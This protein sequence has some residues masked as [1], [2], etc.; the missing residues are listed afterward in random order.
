MAQASLIKKLRTQPGQRLL[1][2]NAPQGY[3]ESLGDLPEGAQV[4]EVPE[5]K[6]DFVHLF[7]TNSEDLDRLR[8]PAMD[9]AEYDGLL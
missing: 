6:F 1:V 3:I 7:V 5:G 4:S 9:A 8:R 2:L